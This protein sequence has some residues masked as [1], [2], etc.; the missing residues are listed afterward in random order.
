MFFAANCK[1]CAWTWRKG[2]NW[3]VETEDDRLV[4]ASQ[5]KRTRAASG[6]VELVTNECARTH[7]QGGKQNRRV[8]QIQDIVNVKV[9]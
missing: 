2:K 1:S 9:Q 3:E 5:N 4:M 6:N 7:T 8:L